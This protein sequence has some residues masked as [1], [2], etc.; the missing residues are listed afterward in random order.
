MPG[1]AD[2]SD[3]P[4]RADLQ[5]LRD[6]LQRLHAAVVHWSPTRWLGPAPGASGRSAADVLGELVTALAALGREAGSGAPDD[7]APGRT[8]VHA[9]A[10]QL[11]VVGGELFA[12]PHA[13]AVLDRARAA[14]AEARSALF[15]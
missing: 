14:V 1:T 13:D 11:A 9:L 8:G 6:D 12:T 15:G 7:A 2:D 5:R 4:S 10:D 3:A